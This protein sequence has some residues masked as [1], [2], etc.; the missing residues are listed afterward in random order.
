MKIL[1]ASDHAGV[2]FKQEITKYLHDIGFSVLDL[3]TNNSDSVDYPDFAYLL[4][5]KL[6]AQEADYGILICGSGIGMSIA[7][8]R[9][10]AIRGAL[11]ITEQ[12]AELSRQ[13]N[14]ANVLV[15]GERMIDLATALK[16]TEKFFNTKFEGGRHQVR[17][18][19]LSK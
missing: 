16:I 3:G 13:H 1:I 10:A 17:V 18:D 19:K 11:C 9:N 12:M 8:N 7:V 4:A 15:L 5:D 6:S 2:N 14:N